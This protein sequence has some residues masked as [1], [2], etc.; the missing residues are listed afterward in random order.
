MISKHTTSTTWSGRMP[1][2]SIRI[3]PLDQLR[4]EFG[5]EELLQVHPLQ[6]RQQLEMTSLADGHEI[7]AVQI[8]PSQ[9][10]RA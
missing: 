10:G 5:V 9:G 8:Q 2:S 4:V 6:L 3:H 7:L 1:A